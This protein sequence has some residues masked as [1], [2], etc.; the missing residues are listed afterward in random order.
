VGLVVVG[1]A[2]L[3]RDRQTGTL[4]ALGPGLTLALVPSLLWVLDDP[5]TPRA[6]LLGLGCLALVLAG[7][8]LRWAAP[9]LCGALAGGLLV[10][11]EAAPYVVAAVPRWGLIGAAGVL[12]IALGATWEQ[13]LT[14][15]RNVTGRL[16]A[17]R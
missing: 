9:L 14:D 12:L 5:A 10:L 15:A 17:L 4:R 6:L 16:R 7:A 2:R 3:H 1:L 8:R 11:R 13:R